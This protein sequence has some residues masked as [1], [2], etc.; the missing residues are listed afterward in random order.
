VHRA[1]A[2]S[3]CEKDGVVEDQVVQL[4]QLSLPPSQRDRGEAPPRGFPHT[5]HCNCSQVLSLFSA[6][7]DAGGGDGLLTPGVESKDTRSRQW[8]GLPSPPQPQPP[9][10]E[11]AVT[12]TPSRTSQRQRNQQNHREPE[13]TRREAA[14][15]EEGCSLQAPVTPPEHGL[16][17]GDDAS[18]VGDSDTAVVR[19]VG[20][21]APP[22]PERGACQLMVS[23]NTAVLC[24]SQ[25]PA[26]RV[27]A[28]ADPPR[29][30]SRARRQQD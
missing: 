20:L 19:C 14:D 1:N 30:W 11:A 15:A 27:N 23:Q 17:G 4:Q 8:A 25:Y 13:H 26:G 10:E 7:S 9:R 29:V 6:P 24:L 16:S 18:E 22:P 3:S 12:V 5:P 2:H 21:L 28:P